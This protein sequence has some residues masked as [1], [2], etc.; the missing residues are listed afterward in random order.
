[1]AEEQYPKFVTPYKYAELCGVSASAINSRIKRGAL[2]VEDVPQIDGSTKRFINT[3]K[4]P[5][6]RLIDYPIEHKR[7]TKK[8]DPKKG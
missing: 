6:S 5:P 7:P 1:M 3:E 2:D 8:K 4:F